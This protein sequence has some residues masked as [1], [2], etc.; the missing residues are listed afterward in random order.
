MSLK[1]LQQE[2]GIQRDVFLMLGVG[3]FVFFLL[4]WSPRHNLSWH[5]CQQIKVGHCPCQK[6]GG[7]LQ[8]QSQSFCHSTADQ[9]ILGLL[10]LLLLLLP[11]SCLFLTLF[12]SC[13]LLLLLTDSK[14]TQDLFISL[15]WCGAGREDQ[16]ILTQFDFFFST[17]ISRFVSNNSK[18]IC[19][20]CYP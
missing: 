7:L 16:G 13:L 4:R 11:K 20:L 1:Y 2:Y 14:I 3:S 6:K 12:P 18:E 10:L 19:Q 5:Q 9:S 8:Q 17:P 15:T